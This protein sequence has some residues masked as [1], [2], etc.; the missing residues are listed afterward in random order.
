[1]Q[2]RPVRWTLSI[3]SRPGSHQRVGS[4]AGQLRCAGTSRFRQAVQDEAESSLE[5]SREQG[6]VS[7][8]VQEAV[9]L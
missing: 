2:R 8:R 3:F 4:C 1:M 7:L 9:Q 5:R 6:R